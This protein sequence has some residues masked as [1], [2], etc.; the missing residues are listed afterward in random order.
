MG[1]E[2]RPSQDGAAD[3]PRAKDTLNARPRRVDSVARRNFDLGQWSAGTSERKAQLQGGA[4]GGPAPERR[5]CRGAWTLILVI[6]GFPGSRDNQSQ[7]DAR[8][9]PW[10]AAQQ[11]DRPHSFPSAADRRCRIG[12]DA[13]AHG[14]AAAGHRR[15]G[16]VDGPTFAARAATRCRS[17]RP[18]GRARAVAH[19]RAGGAGGG[20]RRRGRVRHPA[21]TGADDRCAGRAGCGQPADA[22]ATRP[23]VADRAECAAAAARARSRRVLGP[24]RLCRRNA[25]PVRAAVPAARRRHRADAAAARGGGRHAGGR[26]RGVGRRAGRAAAGAGATGCRCRRRYA[27]P[28]G[29]RASR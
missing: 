1:L 12:G 11:D 26:R 23:A 27:S 6:P 20:H 17:P 5:R 15:R 7:R 14:R 28:A 25:E 4:R 21:A 22:A 10:A 3:S 16:A 2:V 13:C 19:H 24:R 9:H 18:A 8:P 29:R